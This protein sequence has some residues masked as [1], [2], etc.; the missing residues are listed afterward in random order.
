MGNQQS[1]N[2]SN[3]LVSNVSNFYLRD[4]FEL[5]KR[6]RTINKAKNEE[7]NIVTIGDNLVMN[8]NNNT[9]QIGNYQTKY[10]KFSQ[11]DR[12]SETIITKIVEKSDKPELI[13]QGQ[14]KF[15]DNLNKSIL[16]LENKF[17]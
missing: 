1:L 15:N 8:P 17:C 11:I 12:K 10:E 7:S 14:N 4:F 6:E 2:E 13:F 9:N 16:F 5:N 3:K